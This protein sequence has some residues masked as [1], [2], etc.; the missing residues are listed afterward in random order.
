MHL[1]ECWPGDSWR[2]RQLW[3][4]GCKVL[5]LG[6]VKTLGFEAFDVAPCVLQVAGRNRTL[7]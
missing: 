7:L 2:Q 1:A 3:V 4:W 5:D 6:D